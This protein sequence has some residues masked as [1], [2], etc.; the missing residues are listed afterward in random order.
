MLQMKIR[1]NSKYAIQCELL[2]HKFY[3]EKVHF[4]QDFLIFHT[5]KINNIAF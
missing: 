2:E 1:P 3:A 5:N 4:I